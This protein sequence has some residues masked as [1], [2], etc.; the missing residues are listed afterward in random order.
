MTA[1]AISLKP[2]VEPKTAV[3]RFLND[4]A[5]LAKRTFPAWQKTQI[6]AIEACPLNYDQGRPVLEVH[7]LDD[8]YSAGVVALEATN[9][10]AVSPPDEASEF[11]SLVD[12]QIDAA[13]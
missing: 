10:R 12:E 6:T 2:I 3:A 9:N 5:K 7:P 11:L 13:A 4:M 8:Y 1:P